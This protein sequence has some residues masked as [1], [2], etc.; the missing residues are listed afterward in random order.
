MRQIGAKNEHTNNILRRKKIQK[1]FRKDKRSNYQ[2]NGKP[3]NKLNGIGKWMSERIRVLIFTLIF[4][5]CEDD[6]LIFFCF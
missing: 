2:R 5:F 6:I 3:L 1:Q 4:N